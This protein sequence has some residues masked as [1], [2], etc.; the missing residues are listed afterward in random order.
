MGDSGR[1][2]FVKFFVFP[3]D[4][5]LWAVH[6]TFVMS[7]QPVYITTTLPYI[8]AE[9]HVGFAMELV[10]ADSCA[11]YFKSQ[12]VDVF[13][14]TG[15][16]EHGQKIYESAKNLDMDTKEYCDSLAEKYKKLVTSLNI[17][18][19]VHFIRTTDESHVAAAQ[20]F[21]KRVADNGFIQKK[22]HRAKY[23]VGCE[24]EK[25]DSELV[26]GKCP[27]HLSREIE[28]TEEENYFFLFSKFQKQLLDLYANDSAYVVG[29]GRFNEVRAFVE[30]GL[31]DFSVSRLKSK[32]PWGIAVPGDESHVMYVWFDALV[33]YI[34]TLG[35]PNNLELFQ[36]FWVEGMTFQYAGKDNVRQQAAMW[37]AMLLAAGLPTTKKIRINGFI[38][39]AGGVKMSKTLGN[40]ISPIEIIEKYGIDALRYFLL[41]H[42]PSFEDGEMSMETFHEAYTADLVNGVGNLASR[43]LQLSSAYLDKIEFKNVNLNEDFIVFVEAGN[44]T[45]ALGYVW[46]KIDELNVWIS[47][48][49]PFSVVKTD[50]ILGKQMIKKAILD[51]HYLNEHLE[52][53]LP[54][55]YLKLKACILSNQ[56]PQ[57]PLFPRL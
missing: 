12:G 38:N 14:N 6:Y 42:I 51:L 45:K 48:D 35:W 10:R 9:P 33:N 7:K 15:T 16:D 26:D 19:D 25:T 57:N 23:C 54:E 21:W 4:T 41:R 29:P 49:K 20:E 36:K 31:Q 1:R 52:W 55:T 46:G 2:V 43:I 28:Y 50:P 17:I 27:L 34:S 30:S 44:F 53:F 22:I 18:S 56:K 13:F 39:G 37:Q 40:T 3:L 24:L 8:N 5:G 47:Q 32:M 11:R